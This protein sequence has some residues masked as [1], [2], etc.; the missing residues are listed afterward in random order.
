V[1]HTALKAGVGW[2]DTTPYYGGGISKGQKALR[3]LSRPSGAGCRCLADGHFPNSGLS[4]F[5][6]LCSATEFGRQQKQRLA[7]RTTKHDRENIFVVFNALQDFSAF[8]YP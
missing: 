8:A 6:H 5:L 1:I 2:F 3:P 4:Y 7:I